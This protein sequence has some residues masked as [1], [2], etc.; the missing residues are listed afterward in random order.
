MIITLLTV[1]WLLSHEMRDCGGTGKGFLILWEWVCMF[2]YTSAHNSLD[3]QQIASV[4]YLF[5]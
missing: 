4:G 5:S 2:Q 1:A 3:I